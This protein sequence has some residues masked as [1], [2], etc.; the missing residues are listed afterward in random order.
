LVEGDLQSLEL[1]AVGPPATLRR[2]ARAPRGQACRSGVHCAPSEPSRFAVGTEDRLPAIPL[3]HFFRKNVKV[4][5]RFQ[6]VEAPQARFT[7]NF[8]YEP[9]S[10]TSAAPARCPGAK[11]RAGELRGPVAPVF[12][13]VALEGERGDLRRQVERVWG[14]GSVRP[15][16]CSKR[17]CVKWA[18]TRRR[19]I[20]LVRPRALPDGQT[21]LRYLALNDPT[22]RRAFASALVTRI[23]LCR[24]RSTQEGRAIRAVTRK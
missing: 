10:S 12:D 3:E 4:G 6:R 9:G 22:N 15:R 7:R 23:R 1:L 5:P 16:T 13:V 24:E 14:D 8:R 21:L 19:T 11:A 2:T 20:L 18:S 17:R